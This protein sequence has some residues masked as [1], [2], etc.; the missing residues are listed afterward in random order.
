M[1]NAIRWV[2]GLCYNKSCMDKLPKVLGFSLIRTCFASRYVKLYRLLAEPCKGFSLIELLVVV[3]LIIILTSI[4]V[5]VYY[6]TQKNA[7]DT[8]RKEDIQSIATAMEAHFVNGT[9]Q[10]LAAS[11]FNNGSF[12]QDP[13]H[14]AAEI[15]CGSNDIASEK[16]CWYCLKGNGR[17]PDFCANNLDYYIDNTNP[18]NPALGQYAQTDWKYCANLEAGDPKFYCVSNRQ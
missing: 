11:W 13:L 9:Y 1:R 12:P 4:S 8:R 14:D 5:G 17:P 3:S 6:D 10:A 16:K 7:R 15:G 18:F 2:V